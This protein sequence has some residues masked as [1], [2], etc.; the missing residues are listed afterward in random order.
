[1]KFQTIVSICTFSTLMCIPT[2]QHNS[3]KHLHIC[4]QPK[5]KLLDLS[6]QQTVLGSSTSQEISCIHYFIHITP[7]NHWAEQ[8]ESNP[9]HLSTLLLNDSF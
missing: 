3:H 2:S 8:N 1:M 4:T 5:S 7:K 9:P 6:T